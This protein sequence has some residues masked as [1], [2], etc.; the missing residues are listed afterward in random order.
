MKKKGKTLMNYCDT[1]SKGFIFGCTWWDEASFLKSRTLASGLVAE[2]VWGTRKTVSHESLIK[3]TWVQIPTQIF[4]KNICFSQSQARFLLSGAALQQF[5]SS[6]SAVGILD[7]YFIILGTLSSK[8]LSTQFKNG[9]E[10]SDPSRS[11]LGR[12]PNE[13]RKNVPPLKD[14]ETSSDVKIGT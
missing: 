8:L 9:V 11:T 13:F 5:S 3:R 1:V 14:A 12:P 7:P 6:S 2:E 4:A 10:R